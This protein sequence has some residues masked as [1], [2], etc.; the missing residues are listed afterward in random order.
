MKAEIK[1]KEKSLTNSSGTQPTGLHI[2]LR[3]NLT[4][5]QKKNRNAISMCATQDRDL[6]HH[7]TLKD[8]NS[9]KDYHQCHL[10][11]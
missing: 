1:K 6:F 11:I 9:G 3:Q 2:N 8:A 5:E 10:I 4:S 7:N